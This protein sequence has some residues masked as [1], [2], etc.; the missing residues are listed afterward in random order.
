MPTIELDEELHRLL[1][2]LAQSP[3][4]SDVAVIKRVLDGYRN[5][6]DAALKAYEASEQDISSTN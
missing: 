1:R 5:E 6:R 3:N 2:S 4:E